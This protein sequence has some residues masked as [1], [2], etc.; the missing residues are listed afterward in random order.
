MNALIREVKDAVKRKYA[1]P[2]GYPLFLVMHDGECLCMDCGRSEFKL[3][4]RA[5]KDHENNGWRAEGVMV[6]WEDYLICCNC[7]EEIEA[8]YEVVK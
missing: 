4:A 2:G 6:N 8:A 5:I 3:I 7:N 1:W